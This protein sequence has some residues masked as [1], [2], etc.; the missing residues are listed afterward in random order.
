MIKKL[1]KSVAFLLSVI[2]AMMI[3]LPIG[4][5]GIFDSLLTAKAAEVNTNSGITINEAS[6]VAVSQPTE[7]D[8]TESTPYLIS[9]VGE[10]YWFA[11]L[12]NG[13]LEGINQNKNA[14]AKLTADITVNQGLLNDDGTIKRTSVT[15]WKPIG[16]SSSN[17]YLGTFDGNGHTISGLYC[18]D[19]EYIGFIGY[20]SNKIINTSIVDSYFC[21]SKYVGSICGYNYYGVIEYCYSDNTVSGLTSDTYVGS[22]C[23]YNYYSSDSYYVKNCIAMI[24]IEKGSLGKHY[25]ISY[26]ASSTNRYVFKNIPDD[27][28][29]SNTTYNVYSKDDF[30]KGKIVYEINGSSSADTVV[31]RQDL[32]SENSRPVPNGTSDNPSPIVYYKCLNTCAPIYTNS[33]AEASQ[34]EHNYVDGICT[35]NCGVPSKNGSYYQIY[36][37]AQLLTFAEYAKNCTSSYSDYVY[38]NLMADIDLS[39]IDNWRPIGNTSFGEYNGYFNG[40]GHTISGIKCEADEAGFLGNLN[41]GSING[42]RVVDSYFKGYS[43]CG[44]ITAKIDFGTVSNCYSD[45][46]IQGLTD[47]TKVCGISYVYFDSGSVRNC[48]ANVNISE[49]SKG[50]HYGIADKYIKASFYRINSN[51]S[52]VAVKEGYAKIA[53]NEDIAS[54]KITYLLNN[55]STSSSVKWRQTIGAKDS[56]P[57]NTSVGD[58]V[59][60][61]YKDSCIPTYVNDSKLSGYSST[62]VH[63][64]INGICEYGC[65]TPE[66]INDVYQIYNSAQL[67]AFAEYS[68]DCG[69]SSNVNGKLMADIDLSSVD[70]WIPIG[71]TAREYYGT[72]DGN[73]HTIS[74]INCINSNAGLFA[75]NYGTIE[76]LI[77]TDSYF[78][79]TSYVAPISTENNKT[80]QNCRTNVTLK[81]TKSNTVVCGISCNNNSSYPTRN[82]LALISIAEGSIGN[83]YGT[84]NKYFLNSY[85]NVVDNAAGVEITQNDAV[86]VD[87]KKLASGEVTYRLNSNID[88]ETTVWR[89]D[90]SVNNSL[91][92]PDSSSP[93]VY[94]KYNNS[95]FVSVYTNSAKLSGYSNTPVHNFVD[96]ICTNGCG[97]LDFKDNAYLIYNIDQ[98][99]KFEDYIKADNYV[100]GKLMKDIDLSSIS[101]WTPMGDTS[102]KY[103]GNFDG[104]G[105]TISGMTCN[106]S[107]AGLFYYNYGTI[108]N[109]SVINSTI[110]S[111]SYGGI[112]AANNYGTID[113]CYADASLKG[114]YS[115]A[116]MGGITGYSNNDSKFNNCYARITVPSGSTGRYYPISYGYGNINNC[117]YTV[118]NKDA[119]VTF[120]ETP[121][122]ETNNESVA[123]GEL[124]YKLNKSVSDDTAIWRQDLSANNSV[125]M[126]SITGPIVYAVYGGKCIA[127]SYSNTADSKDSKPIHN[128]VDGVCQNGCGELMLEDNYYLIYN[129]DQLVKFKE[130]VSIDNTVN[131]RLMADIDLSAIENWSPIGNSY[132]KFYGIFDGNGYS[133]SG[134]TCNNSYAGLFYYN[135]GTIKN[136]S[137]INS[138]LQGSKY[139]GAI[140]AYNYGTITDCYADVSIKGTE[141]SAY[142]GGISYC[143]YNSTGRV[144]NCYARITIPEGSIGKCYTISYSNSSYCYYT[145]VANNANTSVYSNGT[146][147]SDEDLASGMLTYKLN[148]SLSDNS[149][150]WRQDLFVEGSRPVPDSRGKIVF[151]NN[152]VYQNS[153]KAGD[154]SGDNI[155]NSTDAALVL[156]YINGLTTLTEFARTVADINSDGKIDIFDVIG[157]LNLQEN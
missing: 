39:S 128:Y 26:S 138:T 124:T 43:Y 103:Y 52:N 13:T 146:K 48:L 87:S 150:V 144:N 134:L 53:S 77:I 156:K 45:A 58:I 75:E 7:G 74:G 32:S 21:G 143:Y 34:I 119:N 70:N 17:R 71:N 110:K 4:T 131:G 33:T 92:I 107:Y 137:I 83:Y 20:L 108:K 140:A 69:S 105:H 14:C 66:K 9:T 46:T 126:P 99:L 3:N 11:G 112:I 25:T 89:Q 145:I 36:D 93:I 101:N 118:V 127:S 68:K 80:I 19:E 109:L 38:A 79:G 85:Y 84:N 129:V 15:Q 62:P 97:E 31:W 10:L 113:N 121:A 73:S 111:S 98:F 29:F 117:Y 8:G 47:N 123:N 24:S 35:N 151:L 44:T 57:N 59:Y 2:L 23:G 12:V 60:A 132:N 42:L 157:I 81:G 106:N 94:G 61:M 96:G 30:A 142:Y 1:K 152:N 67:L 51:P 40:N 64:F 86:E 116:D 104:N 27:I 154:V 18:S 141:S 135:Y 41:F 95:C 147:V 5:S 149:V 49:N 133:I 102:N 55:K 91:P 136:L 120:N 122:I 65:N 37:K 155:V 54:G 28:N 125:P 148:K 72:F 50:D 100:N 130:Y 90:L 22:V 139:V 16:L 82:N 115:Y 78:E 6:T 88:D 114:T 153:K 76:N 56:M 63:N